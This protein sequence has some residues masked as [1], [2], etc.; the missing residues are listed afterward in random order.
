MFHRYG[1][2]PAIVT[3]TFASGSEVIVF[4]GP[5]AQ[6]HGVAHRPDGSPISNASS[7]A[8][9]GLN[10][11]AVQPQVTA[12]LRDEP[13]RQPETIRRGD[14]TYLVSQHFRNQLLLY[15][16]FY[17][18]FVRIAEE[19]WP[20]LQIKELAAP[21]SAGESIKLQVRDSSF[22][23]EV[24]LMG[25]GLQMWL[26]IVWFL[27]RAPRE[28]TVVLDEPDVYMHPD[29]QRRLLSL[30]RTRFAQLLIA[31]HSI[32]I[33]SDVDPRSI[34]AV[35]RSKRSSR[36]VASLPGL[37]SVLDD[38]G[39]VQNIQLTRLMRA[40]SFLLVEGKDLRLL[41]IFQAAA[42]V[43]IRPIDLIPHA[44]LNGRGGWGSG[45]AARLPKKN[46]E[47]E[48]IR[49]FAILDRDYF[50][51]DEVLERYS[52]AR[53]WSIQ[54]RVWSQ[55]EIENYVL[56]P[57]AIA[58]HIRAG[59][60]LDV[61]TPDAA[62]I[63]VQLDRIAESLRQDPIEVSFA[64]VIHSRDKKGGLPKAVK[65][66]REHVGR[67][68]EIQEARWGCAPGKRVVSELSLWS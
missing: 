2:P 25:H 24:N 44:E 30:V 27:A 1:D 37:Q 38:L 34:L 59:A 68:W 63:S 49:S 16:E 57:E 48:K 10:S 47:G 7:I 42:G 8:T 67:K 31:T 17:E 23:G 60:P 36:F 26:Q 14:G 19:S 18:E 61:E 40:K 33:I 5:G 41:R 45:V 11:I 21:N 62:A 66:A 54:L 56:I 13:V 51:D 20:G 50:P 58:R 46:L 12:L 28:A 65:T 32:E 64:S 55:K 43:G 3:A 53:S 6:I 39:S 35:D 15:D 29:L 52:E 4:V 22:V 9:L